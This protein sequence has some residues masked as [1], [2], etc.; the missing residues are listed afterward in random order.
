[1]PEENNKQH[2]ILTE[3][4]GAV[5]AIALT[6]VV[7]NLY[8]QVDAN[9]G[10]GLKNKDDI[11]TSKE[12]GEAEIKRS[13][14]IDVQGEIERNENKMELKEQDDFLHRIDKEVGSL[15]TAIK[16]IHGKGELAHEVRPPHHPPRPKE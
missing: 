13:T 4:V 7:F 16:Y 6:T 12:V 8:N 11:A 3:V 2:G 9:K 5:I 14:A 15:T 1:M 10:T